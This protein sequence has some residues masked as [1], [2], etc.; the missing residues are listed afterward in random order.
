MRYVFFLIRLYV[1]IVCDSCIIM[2]GILGIQ[3][4]FF[5]CLSVAEVTDVVVNSIAEDVWGYED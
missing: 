1:V 3:T 4:D 2:D 5:L